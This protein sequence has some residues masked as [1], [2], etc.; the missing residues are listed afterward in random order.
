MKS[1]SACDRSSHSAGKNM[2]CKN[3]DSNGIR[4]EQNINS[5]YVKINNIRYTC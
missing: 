1:H 3:N 2:N 5:D 4:T